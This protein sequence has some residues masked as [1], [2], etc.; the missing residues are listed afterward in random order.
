LGS[1]SGKLFFDGSMNLGIQKMV[2]EVFRSAN[3]LFKP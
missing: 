3:I 1:F 2:F